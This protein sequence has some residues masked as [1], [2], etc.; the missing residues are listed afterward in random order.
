MQPRLSTHIF[1]ALAW[2]L[3]CPGI[4][5][6]ILKGKSKDCRNGHTKNPSS[7]RTDPSCLRNPELQLCNTKQDFQGV[8]HLNFPEV[9]LVFVSSHTWNKLEHLVFTGSVVHLMHKVIIEE[10]LPVSCGNRLELLSPMLDK[11]SYS[12]RRHD[13]IRGQITWLLHSQTCIVP[14]RCCWFFLEF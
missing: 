3:D 11:C 4:L 13:R 6:R 8:K 9:S 1:L 7:S 2:G 10:L 14:C 5:L 12:A